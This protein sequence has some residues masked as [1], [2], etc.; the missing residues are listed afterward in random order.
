VRAWDVEIGD[1]FEPEFYALAEDVQDEIL[2]HTRLL[3]EYGP[4]LGRPRVDTLNG[5]RHANMKELRFNAA[6]GVWRVAFAFDTRRHAIL[7][8]AGDKSGGSKRRFYDDLVRKADQR[9]DAH[10]GRLKKERK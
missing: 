9:F 5:S 3:Q 1:E 8:A 4:Q 2:A 6:D 7:L 10:L